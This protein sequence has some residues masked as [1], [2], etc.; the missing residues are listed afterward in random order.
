MIV[1]DTNLLI[2]AYD[3]SS[4]HHVKAK[5][6]WESVL[7]G[8]EPV[9]IPWVVV[10]AFVRI[11]T[12]PVACTRPLDVIQVRNEVEYWC[13][14]SHIRLLVPSEETMQMFFYL[15]EEADLGGNLSTDALIAAHAIEHA[16]IVYSNDRDF[17]RF[18]QLRT[19]NPLL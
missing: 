18:K 19:R 11:M 10:L 13:D 4:P 17:G 2:Y 14:F 15:L 16:A 8:R 7:S 5:G 3:R 6:W 9:G 12:H 1:P